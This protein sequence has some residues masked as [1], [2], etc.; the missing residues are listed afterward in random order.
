MPETKV[1]IPSAE[2]ALVLRPEY[3]IETPVLPGN[4][5]NPLKAIT[6]VTDAAGVRHFV[7]TT[8]LYRK[9]DQVPDPKKD[10][11]DKKPF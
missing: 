11:K 4:Y 8:N 5:V 3:R 10:D 7:D 9:P 1:N 6:E 2:N